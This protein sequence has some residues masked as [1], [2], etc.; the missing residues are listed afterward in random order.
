MYAV[1]DVVRVRERLS[2]L[3]SRGSP[4]VSRTGLI[5]ARKVDFARKPAAN[6]QESGHGTCE[7]TTKV[8]VLMT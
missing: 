1:C 7:Q 6:I 3:T 4:I 8:Y 5:T 2:G